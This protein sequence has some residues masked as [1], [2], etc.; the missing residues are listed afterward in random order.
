MRKTKQSD[1]YGHNTLKSQHIAGKLN[2]CQVFICRCSC[3]LESS[4]KCTKDVRIDDTPHRHNVVYFVCGTYF[5]KSIKAEKET[6]IEGLR[7]D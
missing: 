4:K 2:W 7:I 1:F 6:T 5:E 3:D